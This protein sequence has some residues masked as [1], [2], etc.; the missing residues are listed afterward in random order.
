VKQSLTKH[1]T[2]QNVDYGY[3]W[4]IKFLNADGVRYYGRLRR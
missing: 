4:W 1:L 3:L 2:V